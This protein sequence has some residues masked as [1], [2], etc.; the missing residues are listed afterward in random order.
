MNNGYYPSIFYN[1]HLNINDTTALSNECNE[2]HR[3]IGDV[4]KGLDKNNAYILYRAFENST[5][6][7]SQPKVTDSSEKLINKQ[8]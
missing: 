8:K 1:T 6:A 3:R 4:F 7:Q 2:I 5:P